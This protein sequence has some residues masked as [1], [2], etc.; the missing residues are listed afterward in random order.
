MILGEEVRHHAQ[1]FR[2][3]DYADQS[4]A[5]VSL[6][7]R[8][9]FEP[10]RVGG[11]HAS[12]LIQQILST[13]AERGG[14]TAAE[15]WASLI[16]SGTFEAIDKSSFTE[17]LQNLGKLDLL[18]QSSNGLLFHGGVGE[19]LVNHYEFYSAFASD[20]EFRVIAGGR[21]LGSVPMAHPLTKGQGLIFG[22][23]RWRVEEVDQEGKTIYVTPDKGGAPP[24]FDGNG[25]MV[26]DEV[27][28]GMRRLLAG[29]THIVSGHRG[30]RNAARGA[31]I[32][33]RSVTGT[34]R[35]FSRGLGYLYCHVARRLSK[36]RSGPAA[37]C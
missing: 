33:C 17:V 18:V 16:V 3:M 31:S 35:H 20:E 7:M 12:T 1:H 30:P 6:L 10:P 26:H 24:Q 15:L 11:M 21:Q 25:A 23:R 37:T 19:K 28:R 29:G 27:R 5:M 36:R 32:L 14:C 22:G 2:M 34:D 8:G 13:I 4:V 9:W